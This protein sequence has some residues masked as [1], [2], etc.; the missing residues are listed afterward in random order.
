M[1]KDI[2]ILM[3]GATAKLFNKEDQLSLTSSYEYN[4]DLPTFYG[5]FQELKELALKKLTLEKE[6]LEGKFLLEVTGFEWEGEIEEDTEMFY[7]H[8]LI[9]RKCDIIHAQEDYY[10]ALVHNM[11]PMEKDNQAYASNPMD[12]VKSFG[13]LIGD[14]NGK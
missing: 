1:T 11:N 5:S 7:C 14:T 4:N 6:I 2:H 13:W 3:I 8:N 9:T 10:K 12:D